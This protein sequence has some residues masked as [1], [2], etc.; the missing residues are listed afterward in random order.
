MEIEHLSV[1]FVYVK[2]ENLL[3][4]CDHCNLPIHEINLNSQYNTEIW[5]DTKIWRGIVIFK[6]F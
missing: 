3:I 6:R 2:I 4:L 5:T 1:T